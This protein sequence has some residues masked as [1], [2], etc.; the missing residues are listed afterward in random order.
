M[1]MKKHVAINRAHAHLPIATSLTHPNSCHYTSAASIGIPEGFLGTIFL[2]LSPWQWMHN[3]LFF[4][5]R[6]MVF[7]SSSTKVLLKL[8]GILS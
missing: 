2:C 8:L 3:S 5:Q 7:S 6:R 4:K 1:T